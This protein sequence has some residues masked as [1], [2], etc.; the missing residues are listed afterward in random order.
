MARIGRE[1]GWFLVIFL[2]LSLAVHFQAWL[3]HPLAHLASLPQSPMG[4]GHPFIFAAGIYL[5]VGIARL[6]FAALKKFLKR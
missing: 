1:A 4:M 2:I 5:V 3:D 6:F